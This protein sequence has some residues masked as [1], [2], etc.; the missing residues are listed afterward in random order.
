MLEFLIYDPYG[1]YTP[2]NSV[3]ATV[4]LTGGTFDLFDRY[5]D[6]QNGLHTHFFPST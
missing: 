1:L 2:T 4:T 3:T 6:G 5:C